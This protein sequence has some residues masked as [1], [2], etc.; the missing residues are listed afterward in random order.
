[1]ENLKGKN[2]CNP[3]VFMRHRKTPTNTVTHPG[4]M[5]LKPNV[6]WVGCTDTACKNE[7]AIKKCSKHE[8][9]TQKFFH[10]KFTTLV[11]SV[12]EGVECFDGFYM[13]SE[14]VDKGTLKMHKNDPKVDMYVYKTFLALKKIHEKY[15][16]FRHNDLH[17]DNVLIKGDQPL[18]YDFEL[19]NWHGN[20][21]FDSKFKR[22]YGIYP[23]NNPMYDFHFFVNSISADLPARF[24]EKALT[25]FPPE[26]LVQNSQVVRDFRLRQD[27]KHTSLPTMDQVIQAFSPTNNKMPPKKVLFPKIGIMTFA[28]SSP[29]P[30]YL[31]QNSQVVRDFRL[32]QDVKHTSLP[33]MDQVIQAFSPTN[34]KMP[35][36]KVLF[37]K[38]GIMT[39]ASSSPPP[40]KKRSPVAKKSPPV[41]FTLAN[42]RRVSNRKAELLR[43]ERN[44]LSK[45][46]MKNENIN[47]AIRNFNVRAELNAIR[48][49]ETLKKTGLLTPSPSPVKAGKARGFVPP[50]AKKNS[51]VLAFTTT[52]RRRP[53]INKKLCSSYKKEELM[54]VMKKLG[55]RVNKTMSLKEMC[56]KLKPAP[57]R[58]NMIIKS[59]SYTRPTGEAILNVRK[60][61]YPKQLRKPLY[62]LAKEIGVNAKYKNTKN[63]LVE[64]IYKKLNK[65]VTNVLKNSNVNKITARQIAERLAKNYKWKNDRHVERVRLLKIYTNTR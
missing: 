17:V 45:T 56:A 37:P 59:I 15:P 44:R 20:P 36:K 55:H 58:R 24:K 64:K 49:I 30:E 62:T 47:Q 39:F 11:P 31:V 2:L 46:G 42:K 5:A 60:S 35:P 52:P 10:S 13:Y 18:L 29:P 54:A 22:D 3:H 25:V 53:R 27:V 48:N 28:S 8:F 6:V 23:G 4:I 21:I 51:V 40:T 12:Y 16:S 43:V 57:S 34:N 41:K 19:S 50:A 32:R 38:I 65:N 61:T 26:Y 1:M 63:T 9:N 33:T 7:I 14:F